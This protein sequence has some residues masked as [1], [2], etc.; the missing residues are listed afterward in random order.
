MPKIL[1]KSGKCNNWTC[2]SKT[3]LIKQKGT[4]A[5]SVDTLLQKVSRIIFS[6]MLGHPAKCAVI[7][8]LK[9]NKSAA[10]ISIK[11]A[12]NDKKAYYSLSYTYAEIKQMATINIYIHY[13]K[14]G[15]LY[16]ILTLRLLS[17]FLYIKR[18]TSMI[19]TSS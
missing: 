10:N 13:L 15:H 3:P 16:N 19:M 8:N 12:N 17:N 9:S 11:L 1:N 18:E 5:K 7:D 2:Q 14:R 6:I 4:H